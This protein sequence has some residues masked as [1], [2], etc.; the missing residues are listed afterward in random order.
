MLFADIFAIKHIKEAL[1]LV[2]GI[3]IDGYKDVLGGDRPELGG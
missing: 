1:Y 3:N 2:I